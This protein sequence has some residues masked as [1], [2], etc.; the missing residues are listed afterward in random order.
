[1]K[2]I[3]LILSFTFSS[4]SS[5]ASNASDR[6]RTLPGFGKV[7]D[8]EFAGSLPIVKKNNSTTGN[9]FYW[10]VENQKK[11][12]QVPLVLWLNGGPGAASMYGFFKENGPYEV[13]VNQTLTKRPYSWTLAADYLVIDQPAGV[14][15]S[16]GEQT[17]YA[18]EAEA[19]DQLYSALQLFFTRHPGLKVKSIYLAGESY[20]GKYIPQLALRI[21]VG[22]KQQSPIHLVGLLIGDGWVSPKIQQAANIDYAYYHG[23]IDELERQQVLKLYTDCAQEIDQHTPSSR[24]ANRV[25]MKI[26][27]FIQKKSGNLNLANIAKGKEPSDEAMIRYLNNPQVREV[28]HVDKRIKKFSTF[29]DS[30]A[31]QLE[32][33]E[34]DSVADLYTQILA[35]DIKVILYNGLEDGKD[36]NF[37]STHL[38]L[39]VLDWPYKTEFNQAATCVWSVNNEVAGYAK[40]A[41]GLTQVKIRNAGHLAPIDQPEALYDLFKHFIENKPLC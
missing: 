27:E 10:Y 2:T 34:Q 7:T 5:F 24:R 33:G 12:P 4:F 36:S 9:L 18:N 13:Q 15:L 16:Y 17:T 35:S 40:S 1:M 39:S 8:V 31:Q 32:I 28:L 38:W 6:I 41:H 30:V 19:I 3:V 23:L 26:Q 11:D 20:A 21:I 22:N 29:S 25:C 14:G 37:L